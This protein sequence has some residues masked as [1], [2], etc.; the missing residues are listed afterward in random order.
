MFA[1]PI[2]YDLVATSTEEKK[3]VS[4]TLDSIISESLSL[5]L[6]LSLVPLLTSPP[7]LLP[8]GYIVSN[9]YY[10]IDVT[11]R[12]TRWGVWS[13]NQLNNNQT[14]ADER[15]LNSL[16]ILSHLLSVYR[17]TDNPVYLQSWMVNSA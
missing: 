9:D 2:V 15:G 4:G 1:Y 6:T 5:S 7:P 14:W 12:S 10:L 13:P 3:E 11:N 16:Q 8:P 17:I